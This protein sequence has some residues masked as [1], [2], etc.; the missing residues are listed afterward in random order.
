MLFY[1]IAAVAALGGLPFGYDTGVISDALLFIRQDLA[2]SP[3]VQGFVVGMVLIGAMIGAVIAMVQE[4]KGYSP[5][6]IEADLGCRA[7]AKPVPTASHPA[8]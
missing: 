1:L 7:L 4:T 8:E 5:E 6:Q 2:L 3:T